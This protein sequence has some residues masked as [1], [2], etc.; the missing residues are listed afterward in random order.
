MKGAIPKASR[1]RSTNGR[2]RK[3]DPKAL[4]DTELNVIE[5][6]DE[7][8]DGDLLSATK[9]TGGIRIRT[10]NIR[11]DEHSMHLTNASC[12]ENIA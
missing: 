2:T 3:N 1:V 8:D 10:S 9:V 7:P 4:S 5:C 12:I 11:Q 6:V